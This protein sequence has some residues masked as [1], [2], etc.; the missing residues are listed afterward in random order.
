MFS[1]LFLNESLVVN[2]NLFDFS[3]MLFFEFVNLFVMAFPE[4]IHFLFCSFIWKI[5]RLILIFVFIF[6]LRYWRQDG[7][8]L[9]KIVKLLFIILKFS[10]ES[11]DWGD[12]VGSGGIHNSL[13]IIINHNIYNLYL[14]IFETYDSFLL[15]PT[16]WKK[17]WPNHEEFIRRNWT[18]YLQL[19]K[20]FKRRKK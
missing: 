3:M 11:S 10:L 14:E 18:H 7:K 17:S 4:S 20:Y 5:I 12:Y 15:S 9:F 1:L 8:I 13:K 6:V 19:W 16:P 2:F